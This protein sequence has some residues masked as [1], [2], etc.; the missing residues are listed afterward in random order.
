MR[1]KRR[2]SKLSLMGKGRR[3]MR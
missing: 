3:R 1:V 2:G